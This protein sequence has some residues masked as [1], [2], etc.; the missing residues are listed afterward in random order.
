MY[1]HEEAV[2]LYH[3]YLD[4]VVGRPL[5]TEQA[6]ELP[7]AHLKIEELVDHSFNVFCYGKGSLTFH[8]FRNIETVAKDLE[9]PSPSEVLEE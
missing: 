5:D 8:F 1:T 9:L 6:K 2:K 3:Y 4:K 7:I